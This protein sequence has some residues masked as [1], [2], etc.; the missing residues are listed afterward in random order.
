[1]CYECSK[2]H[3]FKG[4][5]PLYTADKTYTLVKGNHKKETKHKEERVHTG[6]QLCHQVPELKK[7][8]RL[9]Q[10]LLVFFN[11]KK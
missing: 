11:G 7:V 3:A 5:W 2:H 6:Y 10:C 8:V 1:M 4:T 9:K